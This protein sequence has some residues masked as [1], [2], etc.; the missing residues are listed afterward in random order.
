MG[1][2]SNRTGADAMTYEGTN[3]F[4]VSTLG[5][6]LFL[7]FRRKSMGLIILQ[8]I[9]VNLI[10]FIVDRFAPLPEFH[11]GMYMGTWIVPV[12]LLWVLSWVRYKTPC[13]FVMLFIFS[14]AVGITF[15]FLHEPMKAY[16]E[17]FATDRKKN[18]S[19]Q[20][21][22]MAGHT[23]ALILLSLVTCFKHPGR[24]QG[25]ALVKMAPVAIIV[26]VITDII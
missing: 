6:D 12:V 21:Y 19:P 15:G 10:A 13:N 24:Q 3:P 18:W 23:I 7:Q 17:N 26:A 22:G 20:C 16:T 11:W 14:V 1:I 9:F 4:A 25:R 8:S 5:E 2:I